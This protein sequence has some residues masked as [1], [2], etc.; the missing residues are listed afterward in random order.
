MKFSHRF[1][2]FLFFALLVV[3][4]VNFFALRHFSAQYFSEYVAEVRRG[5]PDIN[6]DLIGAVIEAK[7][8]DEKTL[9]EY[10]DTIRDLSNI[11]SGLE[12]FSQNPGEFAGSSS[13][14]KEA[15]KNF[16][17]DPVTRSLAL[18]SQI[19]ILSDLLSFRPFATDTPE[20]AFA[21]KMLTSMMLVNG[22]LI[23]IV[24]LASYVF[25]RISFRP[26]ESVVE[27][28][29]GIA[30]RRDYRPLEYGRKDE[31]RP[32]I[33][34]INELS[35]GL[36]RQEKIRSDFLSDLSHEIK[37]PIT[38]VKCYLEGIEDGVIPLDEKNVA[39]LSGEIGRLIR[40]ADSV[41]RME[42]LESQNPEGLHPEKIDVVEALSVVREEY[43]PMFADA[44]QTVE[45]PTDKRFLLR[46]DRDGLSQVLHNAFSNFAKYAGKGAVLNVRFYHA[47]TESVIAF[48]DNGLGAPES[49]VPFLREKFYQ[50]EKSRTNDPGRGTGIG[51]SVIEKIVRLHGGSLSIESAEGKG[52]RLE[53]RIPKPIGT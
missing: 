29:G 14:A 18:S 17:S 41:I 8:L 39:V 19:P 6:L 2:I 13:V 12:R 20:G 32:L 9:S 24:L 43:S 48:S 52:F 1:T 21:S 40:I 45:F 37:T 23:A 16:L 44:R 34:A 47:K 30:N 15:P 31:F 7:N 11:S 42:R 51:L 35:A 4:N 28:I 5:R 33:S 46:F 50:S 38:A 3:I 53:I 36:T 22:A 49:E 26:L 10:R 25:I 27:R